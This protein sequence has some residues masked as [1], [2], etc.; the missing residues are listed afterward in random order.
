MDAY[1]EEFYLTDETNWNYSKY[2]REYVLEDINKFYVAK[3][4][5]G[6]NLIEIKKFSDFQE[7]TSPFVIFDVIESFCR[8]ITNYEGFENEIN[9]ILKLKK[10][11]VVLRGGEIHSSINNSFLLDSTLKINEVG[12]EELIRVAEDLYGKGKY[13]YAVEK[14]WDAFERIKTSYPTL[15][16]KKSVEK[17]IND[18]SYG[19]EQIKKMFDNEF[20]ILTDIGNSYRIRHHEI[21]RIDISKE[22]HYK[23]FYKRCLALISIILE[24]LQ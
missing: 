4:Y 10:I 5:V 9:T 14:I 18:I 8:H 12:L 22:L 16:K 13:S 23:Y 24:N 17:I 21:N 6:S 20:K 15:D 2:S 19:S 7:G 1:D 3:H 11:N